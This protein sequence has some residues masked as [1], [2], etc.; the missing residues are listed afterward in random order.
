MKERARLNEKDPHIGSPWN[1]WGPYLAERAWGTVRED[2]SPDG[3]AWSYLPFEEAHRKPFRW[4]EDGICGWCDRYQVL[5]FAPAFWNGK[6]PLLKERLYGL[7]SHQGNHGED[8][9]EYYYYLDGTPTH[10]YMKA[11]YK[12]PQAAFPYQQLIEKNA[13]RSLKEPEYELIDTGVFE[14]NAYFDITIEY[15]KE[16]AEDICIRIVATNR[17]AEAAPLAILPQLWFRNQWSWRKER[18]A[19][20]SISKGE[21]LCLVADDSAMASP[22]S[23]NFD[24]HLGKRYLYGSEGGKLLFTDNEN[25]AKD[26]FHRYIVGKEASAI[27]SEE[28]GTKACFYYEFAAIEP[29]QS[30][31]VHLRLSDHPLKDPLKKVD[32]IFEER[33]EEADAFYKSVHPEKASAEECMIQR[34][35]LGGMIWNK[36]F[37]YFDVEKWLKGDNENAPPPE[38]RMDI[39]NNHWQHLN[40]MRILSVPDAW[41][42]P[43]FAAWDLAFHCLSFAL[44]DIR[45]AKEQL[46]LLLFEQFQHPNGA[47]PAY[48]WNFSDLNPPVQAWVAWRLYN[49]EKEQTGKNDLHFLE[50]CFFKLMLNFSFWVNQVDSSGCN[51]FEGGFLGLDNITLF[52]R[53]ERLLDNVII[54]QSDGTGWMAMFS[55]NLMRIS[56]ELSNKNPSYETIATKFFQHFIHIGAALKTRGNKKYSLWDDQDGFFYDTLVY[57]DGHFSPF[58]VRSLVGLIPLFAVESLKKE[59]LDTKPGFKENLSWFLNNRSD[60]TSE[61]IIEGEDSYFLSLVSEEQLVKLLQYIVDP[62]EFRSPYGVRSLSKF[63]EKDPFQFKESQIRYEPGVAECNVKGG[64]SNW[65]GPIWFPINYLL[66]ESLEK[67][68]KF[69]PEIRTA[70]SLSATARSISESLISLFIKNNSGK[71]P[72]FKAFNKETDPHFQD[73]LQFYEYFNAETGEGLGASH[74]TGWT[75]LV[76][77]LIDEYRR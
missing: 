30:V 22:S 63:H 72:I 9:K 11:L 44:I 54:K 23:L 4:G 41:E 60:L 3:D 12:Y 55:L 10:S 37:Y 6:D 24:Y 5:S 19:E 48:E 47:I 2:Y 34:Q 75:G 52:D 15:A 77:N 50:N 14:Q 1:K 21:P 42:Y 73:L 59:N 39:R 58:R 7:N 74:Q 69:F 32:A 28:S 76:A 56:L 40:S 18:Q 49:M 67:F 26:A 46:W 31:T 38:S 27:K 8:V 43:W 20:P 53:S 70:D 17:G 71:R 65:R 25:G 36:Q 68:G 64:N 61:C 66:I 35:A 51:V 45:F 16:G 29:Q 62:N 13:A 57:P 33:I